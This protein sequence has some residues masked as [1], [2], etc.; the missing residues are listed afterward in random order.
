MQ[1]IINGKPQDLATGV[2]VRQLIEAHK[3]SPDKVAVELNQN[4]LRSDGYD[5]PLAEGDQV[6]L[7]TFVGGG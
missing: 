7:V 3:L 2:T 6:E 5:R 1:V 4:L